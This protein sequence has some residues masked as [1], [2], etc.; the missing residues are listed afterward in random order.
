MKQRIGTLKKTLQDDL[1]LLQKTY[2]QKE[3][4]AKAMAEALQATVVHLQAENVKAVDRLNEL[5]L[6]HEQTVKRLAG[7][8]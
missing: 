4:K 2:L 5:Q 1:A 7:E 6:G 3:K 8:V